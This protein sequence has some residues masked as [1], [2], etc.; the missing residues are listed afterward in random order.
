MS[1]AN[2]KSV[3]LLCELLEIHIREIDDETN[4]NPTQFTPLDAEV[5]VHHRDKK[6]RKITDPVDRK[7]F[8]NP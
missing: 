1:E 6:K 7:L 3:K 5:E 2:N 4:W 8:V